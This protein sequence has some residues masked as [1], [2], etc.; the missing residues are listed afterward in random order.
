M[1][2]SACVYNRETMSGEQAVEAKL[3][4]RIH[5]SASFGTPPYGCQ[6]DRSLPSSGRS[7]IRTLCAC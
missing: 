6:L 3:L 2:D 1:N 4:L 7:A 5:V